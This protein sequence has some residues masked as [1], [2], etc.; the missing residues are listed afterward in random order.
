MHDTQKIAVLVTRALIF[1][2]QL[3]PALRNSDSQLHIH[4]RGRAD[5]CMY[6]KLGTPIPFRRNR[7]HPLFQR[8]RLSCAFLL[9][10]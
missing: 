7:G 5:R 3:A 8:V 1:E 4:T 9:S 2:Y 10:A 6:M